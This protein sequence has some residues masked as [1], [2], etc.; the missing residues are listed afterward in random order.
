MRDGISGLS[1]SNGARRYRQLQPWYII[2][3][4]Q[5]YFLIY[6]S[7]N[8]KPEYGDVCRGSQKSP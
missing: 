8:L 3:G 6:I 2:L 7:P 4:D 1:G 5:F